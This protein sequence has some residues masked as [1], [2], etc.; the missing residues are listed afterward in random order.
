[1][2]VGPIRFGLRTFKTALAVMIC[3]LLFQLLD[4]DAPLIACLAAVFAMREDVSTTIHF[5]AYRVIGNLLGGSLALVY[6]YIYR[7]LN[8]NFYAELILIPL[9]VI[10][11]IVFS[12][13]LNFNPGIVGACATLFIIVLTV[14]EHETLLYA[15]SRIMD[16]VIGTLVALLVNRFIKPPVAKIEPETPLTLD[17]QEEILAQEKEIAELKQQLAHYQKKK[18]DNRTH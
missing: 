17:Y 2:I 11:I 12:D 9:F 15:I 10:F 8:Y 13:A 1:M 18:T 5:G 6:I 4:R 7:A 16:T 14:P 3:I